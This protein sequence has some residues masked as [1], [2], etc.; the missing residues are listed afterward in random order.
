MHRPQHHLLN[1]RILPTLPPPTHRSEVPR[2]QWSCCQEVWSPRRPPKIPSLHHSTQPLVDEFHFGSCR[3]R[4][5]LRALT[6]LGVGWS[7]ESWGWELREGAHHHQQRL[8]AGSSTL[9][10]IEKVASF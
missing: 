4:E 5:D 10:A 3:A 1:M 8:E 6:A 2:K 9:G 7:R